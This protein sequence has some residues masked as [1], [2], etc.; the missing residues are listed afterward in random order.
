MTE[1]KYNLEQLSKTGLFNDEASDKGTKYCCLS[2]FFSHKISVAQQWG[3]LQW[4]KVW[5]VFWLLILE[6]AGKNLS[7]SVCFYALLLA[8]AWETLLS[9]LRRSGVCF[10]VCV[11]L[12]M[13]S[14]NV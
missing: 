11:P 2:V 1:Q 5:V 13:I 12:D 14:A 6:E 4:L 3:G 10:G 7:C 9:P 8:G